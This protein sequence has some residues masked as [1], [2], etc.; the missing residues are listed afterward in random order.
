MVSIRVGIIGR[1][2]GQRVVARAYAD[3]EGCQ[4]VEV[5]SPRDE[6][7][8]A[9]LCA[10]GDVDLITVHSPPFLHLD[11]VRRAIETGHAVVC[12]KPFGRHAGDAKEMWGLA[13]EAGVVNIANFETRFDPT[14]S[15]LRALVREGRVGNPENLQCTYIMNISRF[16]L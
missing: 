10:R 2:F 13:E 9:A 7:A 12:D 8:V 6:G 16:P 3:T 14:R 11:N 5:V 1:G 4:V 15:R